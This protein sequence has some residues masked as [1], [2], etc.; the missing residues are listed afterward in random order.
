MKFKWFLTAIAAVS[1]LYPISAY[2]DINGNEAELLSIIN[3]TRE[4]NG[5]MYQVKQQ[6]RDAAR[7]YLDDPS[8]DCTDEQKQKA[9]NQMFGS[10]Q[11]GIDEGYLVAVGGGASKE[12]AGST[13]GAAKNTP[14]ETAK[15]QAKT[16]AA[17]KGQA[18]SA[19]SGT[20]AAAKNNTADGAAAAGVGADRDRADTTGIEKAGTDAGSTA[21]GADSTGTGVNGAGTDIDSTGTGDTGTNGTGAG[22]QGTAESSPGEKD[23]KETEASPIVLALEQAMN[24]PQETSSAMAS[25]SLLPEVIYPS[26]FI[27]L[28]AVG[29][30]AAAVLAAAASFYFGLF[31]HHRSKRKK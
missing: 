11:Q 14:A 13:D 31:H 9:I 17:T 8:I 25:G 15:A 5:V 20:Q 10:I 29:A 22:Q 6:Y 12:T 16:E 7:A 1:F 18:D 28:F 21:A 26:R 2:A 30:A 19:A 3:S 24:A 23:P 4:Y 27:N